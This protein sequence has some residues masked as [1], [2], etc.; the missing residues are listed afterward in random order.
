M[1]GA[2]PV[3][4]TER[5]IATPDFLGTMCNVSILRFLFPRP[6]LH[7]R[8]GL[9]HCLGLRSETSPRLGLPRDTN[10]QDHIPGIPKRFSR[11]YICHP[12]S[13]SGDHELTCGKDEASQGIDALHTLS[14]RRVKYNSPPM[15]FGSTGLY[16][17]EHSTHYCRCHTKRSRALARRSCSTVSCV[18]W[19][20]VSSSSRFMEQSVSIAS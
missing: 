2:F 8:N 16:V 10:L 5:E 3:D 1:S 19:D 11:L 7:F 15:C 14:T 13:T 20:C 6:R 18:S 12:R 9:G 17:W 4:G